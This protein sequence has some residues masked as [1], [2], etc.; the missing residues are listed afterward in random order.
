MQHMIY[1]NV[2]RYAV[3]QRHVVTLFFIFLC[4]QGMIR[5]RD[6]M[7]IQRLTSGILCVFTDAV[8]SSE[9]GAQQIARRKM[10]GNLYS[11]VGERYLLHG[12][13]PD[14]L[15]DI[16]RQGFSEKLASLKGLFGA[17]NY[18]AEAPASWPRLFNFGIFL[19]LTRTCKRYLHLTD[20]LVVWV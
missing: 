18:F 19:P 7:G 16:L 6:F 15:E 10:P 4:V 12:T 9:S 20:V 5:F 14:H 1:I 17:G 3:S 2:H 13:S 11:E 8:Q